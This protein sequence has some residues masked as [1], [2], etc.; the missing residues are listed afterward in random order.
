MRIRSNLIACFITVGTL[1]PQ[2]VNADS[3]AAADPSAKARM[4]AYFGEL[5]IHSGWSD[6]AYLN[7]VPPVPEDAYR[8]NTGQAI[9]HAN[10]EMIQARQPLDFMALTDHAESMGF[11]HLYFDPNHPLYATKLGEVLRGPNGSREYWGYMN[12]A[13]LDPDAFP[14]PPQSLMNRTLRTNWQH[15]IDLAERYYRPGEFTTFVAYEWSALPAFQNLHRNVI[16]RGIDVPEM[17]FSSLDS[18]NPEALWDWME[19]ARSQGSDLL[20]IPHNSNLSNGLMF[21]LEKHDGNAIDKAYAEQRMRNEPL[22]EI[23]QIKGTSETHFSLSPLDEWA[24]F[25]ILETLIAQHDKISEPK[26]SYVRDAYLSGLKL[27]ENGNS[28]PYKFGLIGSSDGHNASSPVDEDSYHGKMGMLDGTPELRRGGNA[29]HPVSAAYSASGLAGVWAKENTREAIFGALRRK[30]TFAT[31]GTRIKV[32]FFGSWGFPEDMLNQ[33]EWVNTAY[34]QG[35]SMGSDLPARR[36]EN[37]SPTFAIWALKDPASNWLQRAQIIKGWIEDGESREEVYDVIC[38]DD[39]NPDPQTHRCPDNGAQVN[40][41]TCDFS[42]DLGDVVLKGIWTDPDFNIGH[43]AF[44]YLRILENP[45]CR[46]STWEANRNGWDLMSNVPPTIQERA[47]SS[48][49][50]YVPQE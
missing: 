28:N 8:Y 39:L 41:E 6:D 1:L 11:T 47:W 38:S 22:V 33:R 23:T 29:M 46:W 35:V 2:Y 17:P 30:E 13:R 16:F 50:W 31:T 5:H 48:P 26:G 37:K 21:P 10:G 24:D 18:M 9:R 14:N 32:R 42:K 27:E 34:S 12:K 3:V 45:T 36:S 43:Q 49:I 25:E 44:Y 20:A 7:G 19:K 4:Q 15:Y 40:L